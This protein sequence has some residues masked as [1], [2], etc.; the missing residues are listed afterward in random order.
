[1]DDGDSSGG[2][3]VGDLTGVGKVV[4][5]DVAKRTYDDALSPMMREFGELSRDSLKAFRLFTAPIQLV[6][7]YQDR[8]AAFCERVRNKVPDEH[9]REAAADVARPVMEAFASTSDDSPLM[10]MFEELMARAIDERHADKLSPTF[11]PLIQ[12]LSPLE[13]KLVSVL[14]S[15]DQH[16]DVLYEKERQLI[17]AR[18]RTNFSV[19]D[20]GGDDHHLTMIQNL[21][22]KRL[23]ATLQKKLKKEDDY[24]NMEI[25]SGQTLIRF[26]YRLTMFGKWFANSCVPG[27]SSPTKPR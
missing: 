27:G 4:N 9:Q 1:M 6:A 12:S 23:V 14:S 15:S 13:A 5:S 18:L 22:E 24:P 20:F 25:E 7:A 8:F 17:L 26:T 10:T 2:P 19:N 11:A 21:T 16:S 3:L